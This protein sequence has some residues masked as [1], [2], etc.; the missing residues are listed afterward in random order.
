EAWFKDFVDHAC[1]LIQCVDSKGRFIYVNQAWLSTLNYSAE[2]IDNIT[3][4]DIIHP[5]SMELCK[6]VFKQALTGEATAEVEAIFVTKDG[7]PVTVEGSIGVKLDES[8]RFLH[9]FSNFRNITERKRAENDNRL[10]FDISN[11]V[12]TVQSLDDLY[13][14]IHAALG[15]VMDVTNFFIAIVDMQKRTLYFPY[16]TDIEDDDFLPITDFDPAVSLTG[17]VVSERQPVLYK[18]EELEKRAQ[19]GGIWG[20]VPLIWMGTPLIIEDEVLGIVAVQSYTDPNLYSEQDLRVLSCVSDQMASAIARKRAE[21]EL[22]GL[23]KFNERI[24]QNINEGIIISDKDG[25]VTFANEALLNMLGYKAD[26]FFGT[27]WTFI[28]PADH[29]ISVADAN[30]RRSYGLVDR[31]ELTLKHKNGTLI[32]VQVSGSPYYDHKTGLITGTLAVLS[33]VSEFKKVQELIITN[34]ERLRLMTRN[35][36]DV[37]LETD[38][39]GYYTYVSES[40]EPV[41]GYNNN[42][43]LGQRAFDFLH[44]DDAELVAMTIVSTFGNSKVV[45]MEYRYKHKTNGYIWVEGVGRA[46]QNSNNETMVL[47]TIRDI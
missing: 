40:S 9:A 29:H 2:E 8:G 21:E 10:L 27:H 34:E 20:P 17:L 37:V 42:E 1:D 15:R 38:A 7:T 19:K 25:L 14:S 44:P 46:Y 30:K 45:R 36:Q 28:V 4:W 32:P 39:N 18:K 26:E 43:L 47:I 41:I 23:K 35:I 24:V 16:H 13:Q 12:V 22:L 3:F 11:A 6:A 31:Y 33:D 5:D